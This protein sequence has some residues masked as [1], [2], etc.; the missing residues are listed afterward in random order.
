MP[1]RTT[2]FNVSITAILQN[3]KL[4]HIQM[5]DSGYNVVRLS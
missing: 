2:Q 4:L 5:Q 1:Y 3:Q